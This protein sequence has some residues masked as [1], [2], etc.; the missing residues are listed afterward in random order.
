MYSYIRLIIVIVLF[1]VE[2]Y[3]Q[4]KSKIIKLGNKYIFWT[5]IINLVFLL[6]LGFMPVEK[7]FL[8]F[9]SPNEA[10]EYTES[11]DILLTVDGNESTLVI[12][13]SKNSINHLIVPKSE[14]D[15]WKI[16][17]ITDIK[18]VQSNLYENASINIYRY[19]NSQ[20]YYI[21]LIALHEGDID[22]S[23]SL[24]T[25]FY[26]LERVVGVNSD[27]YIICYGY[28]NSLPDFYNVVMNGETIELKL[29]KY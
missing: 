15:S 14:N 21:E 5:L 28:I 22:I 19:N 24:G 3:L 17:I 9:D 6:A 16:G 11:A 18:R 13:E 29:T 10:Y 23:D 27:T 7:L 4:N 2:I 25:D 26:Q 8:R 1:F 20:D 12:G